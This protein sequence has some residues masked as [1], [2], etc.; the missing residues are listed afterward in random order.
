M[1]PVVVSPIVSGAT[2]S[3]MFDNRFGPINQIIGWIAGH[4]TTLLWTISPNLVYPAIL[5]AE[6]WQW[7][8][9][10]FLLLLAALAERRQVAA[11]GGGHRRRRLLAHVLPHRAAGDLAGDGGRDPDPRA[12]PVPAVRHRVGADARA[13]RAR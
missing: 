7:T 8:P 6:V 2:W 5:V 13:A 12:R 10:M 4:E 11:R 3:L 9:F 1:L